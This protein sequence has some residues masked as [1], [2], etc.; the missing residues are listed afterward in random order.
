MNDNIKNNVK[1]S[2]SL[3]CIDWLNAKKEIDILYNENIDLLHVDVIDG[4]YAP[5]YTMGTSIINCFR[6]SFH[7][8]FD[9]HLMVEEPSRIFDTFD[10]R[11]GDRF[12]I[13]QE[14]CRNLHRDL[15]TLR[16]I[17]AKVGVALSPATPINVLDYILEDVD[18]VI[19]MTVNPGFKGGNLVPQAIQKIKDL[20]DVIKERGLNVEVSAD[21]NVS[22]ANIPS[23]V[24]NGAD[25]LVSGS[26]GMFIKNEKLENSIKYFREAISEGL[27]E[28]P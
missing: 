28:R 1:I 20:K 7:R 25:I 17:G 14:C 18:Y 5:D 8:P 23:M 21:G 27:N 4:R 9:Y 19:I 24:A 26:S 11:E 13:H 16:N 22:L 12:C 15:I 10:I 6:D 2:A 3:M